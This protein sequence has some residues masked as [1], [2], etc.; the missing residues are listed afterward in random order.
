MDAVLREV[1]GKPL[2]CH[3]LETKGRIQ[4]G[5][6]W[7]ALEIPCR[8]QVGFTHS[9]IHS[10]NMCIDHL[11][12]AGHCSGTRDT[13]V[14]KTDIIPCSHEFYILDKDEG[15]VIRFSDKVETLIGDLGKII[16]GSPGVGWPHAL[17]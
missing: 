13:K 2:A 17:D 1:G 9:F 4:R 16:S 7:S 11:L 14:D 10:R 12:C 6:E 3:F 5:R 8:S 15:V